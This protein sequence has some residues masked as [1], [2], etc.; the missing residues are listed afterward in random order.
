MGMNCVNLG[1]LTVINHDLD[2]SCGQDLWAKILKPES[3]WR[4]RHVS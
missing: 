3:K 4:T 2:F 1:P